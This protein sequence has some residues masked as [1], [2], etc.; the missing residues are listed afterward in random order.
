VRGATVPPTLAARR[1]ILVVS[2]LRCLRYATR[3]LGEQEAVVIEVKPW[4]VHGVGYIDVT[5]A[6]RDRSVETARLGRESVPDDLE[7]GDEVLVDRAVN[8]IVG[9]RKA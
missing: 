6:Y 5:V 3:V 4:D 1:S 7:A 8:M 9:L 2:C